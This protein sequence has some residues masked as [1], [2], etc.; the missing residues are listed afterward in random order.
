MCHEILVLME[1]HCEFKTFYRV[2]HHCVLILI[3]LEDTL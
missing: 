1:M 3:L 2:M